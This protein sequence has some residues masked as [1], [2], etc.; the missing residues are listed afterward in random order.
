MRYLFFSLFLL[1]SVKDG[2]KYMAGLQAHFELI[3]QAV[4]QVNKRKCVVSL[5]ILLLATFL[6]ENLFLKSEVEFLGLLRASRN[7]F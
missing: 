2:R 6:F 4:L 1:G 3:Q 7:I 5:N